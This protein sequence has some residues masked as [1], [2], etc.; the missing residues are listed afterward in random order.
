MEAAASIIIPIAPH[1]I[2]SAA[3]ALQSAYGQT[4]QCEVL[5]ILDSERRGPGWARNVGLAKATAPFVVFLD[6]DDRLDPTFV[7]RCIPLARSRGRY[8]YT[9]WTDDAG[10]SYAA[11]DCAVWG[12]DSW[13]LVTTLLPTAWARAVGGFDETFSGGEDGEFY[14]HLLTSGYCGKRIAM[15]LVVYCRDGQRSAAFRHSAEYDSTMQLINNRYGGKPVGCCGDAPD[16]LAGQGNIN[17]GMVLVRPK[18]GGRRREVGAV[19]GTLYPPS[20]RTETLIIDARDAQVQPRLWEII[21]TANAP[22]DDISDLSTWM[23]GAM[24]SNA[25]AGAYLTTPPPAAAPV[26]ANPNLAKINRVARKVNGMTKPATF[27]LPDKEY[28]SYTDMRRLMRL[29]GF[30]TCLMS[31]ARWHDP[32]ETYIVV[33]PE[34][35][36]VLDRPTAKVIAWVMEYTGEYEPDLSGWGGQVWA[37]DPAWAASHHAQYVPLGS[38]PN[39]NADPDDMPPPKWDA[40]FVGYMT[41]RRVNML[42]MIQDVKWAETDYP[43]YGKTRHD[44]LVRS[45]VMFHVH[46]HENAEYLAPL[47]IALAAAYRLPVVSEAVYDP[48]VYAA[49][50]RFS[51]YADLPRALHDELAGTGYDDPTQ[52]ERGTALHNLLCYER[53]FGRCV[54]E[55]LHAVE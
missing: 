40:V 48:G 53:P 12:V 3:S 30:D 6:A 8:V 2:G 32:G 18:W 35:L 54:M 17:Q 36:P 31:E 34:P 25:K 24:A 37:S 29:S 28:P 22:I 15:P 39:L 20:D 10:K 5:P 9:D 7:E 14:A 38:H 23:A 44:M 19:T 46:Q 13:H 21:A 27:I 1:H 41:P 55:A 51:A 45:R 43:G 49:A 52:M 26:A 33:T 4:V 50:V 47:R 42:S 11:P 16:P